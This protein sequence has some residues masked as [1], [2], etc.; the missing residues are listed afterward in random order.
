M[1]WLASNDLA[2][3]DDVRRQHNVDN[4]H[5]D[6]DSLEIYRVKNMILTD[7]ITFHEYIVDYENQ[8]ENVC[9]TNNNL[10]R[11]TNM[12]VLLT[13]DKIRSMIHDY[14]TNLPAICASRGKSDDANAHKQTHHI[15]HS[16]DLH[17]LK[18]MH[19]LKP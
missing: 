2:N 15:F 12:R 1:L 8:H 16:L 18:E 5:K 13:P 11:Y 3:T 4:G 19:V 10:P 14:A 6:D 7:F 17:K 9:D